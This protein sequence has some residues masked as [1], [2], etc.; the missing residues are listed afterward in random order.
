VVPAAGLV[1]ALDW[2]RA[3][4]RSV[5]SGNFLLGEGGPRGQVRAAKIW[6]P[7][8]E[9][10]RAPGA[11]RPDT[12][13]RSS[14]SDRRRVRRSRRWS[15]LCM[16]AADGC[17]RRSTRPRCTASQHSFPWAPNP[18]SVA[19]A[20]APILC[21]PP[22]TSPSIYPPESCHAHLGRL[23][24]SWPARAARRRQGECCTTCGQRTRPSS[25]A[26]R[27]LRL[28]GSRHPTSAFVPGDTVH[29]GEH[30]AVTEM[31]IVFEE[32]LSTT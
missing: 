17:G 13:A 19:A 5:T 27:V 24:G 23:P 30:L 11:G 16:C 21:R 28:T 31:L 9:G 15:A 12:S 18:A 8:E 25:T 22:C 32:L 10:S 2:T 26:R 4:F 7:G 20:G 29:R 3:A 6:R 14:N 1:A